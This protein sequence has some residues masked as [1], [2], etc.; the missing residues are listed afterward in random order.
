[1]NTQQV[2]QHIPQKSSTPGGEPAILLTTKE[3][4]VLLALQTQTLE[5]WRGRGRGPKYLK[6][7]SAVRY[8]RREL[9]AF[10]EQSRRRSTSDIPQT[11]P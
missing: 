11:N 8:E 9:E 6:L 4:A 2:P 1:M 10:V 7:G 5:M 3:A